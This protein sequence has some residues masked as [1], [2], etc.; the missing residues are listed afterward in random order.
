MGLWV[1]DTI[2]PQ[3]R[4]NFAVFS[5]PED[6]LRLMNPRAPGQ[7]YLHIA[8][9]LRRVQMYVQEGSHMALVIRSTRPCRRLA[10]RG[11][12]SGPYV[13]PHVVGDHLL[14]VLWELSPPLREVAW[15]RGLICRHQVPLAP[16]V[17]R[18]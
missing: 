1:P 4:V 14:K 18:T 16:N 6:N 11:G 9:D 15:L 13:E 8:A 17:L 7:P 5:K 3:A 12:V 2:T 10:S